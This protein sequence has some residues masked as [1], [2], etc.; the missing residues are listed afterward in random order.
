MAEERINIETKLKITGVEAAGTLDAGQLKF[1]IDDKPLKD[2]VTTASKVA[3]DVKARLDSIQPNKIV[4]DVN[5]N[6]LKSITSQ[7]KNAITA[8]IDQAAAKFSTAFNLN[9]LGGTGQQTRNADGTFGKKQQGASTSAFDNLFKTLNKSFSDLANAANSL[10]ATFAKINKGDQQ[11]EGG[12]FT[13]KFVN[14]FDQF[15]GSV[16]QTISSLNSLDSALKTLSNSLKTAAA[17]PVGAI[18]TT[19]TRTTDGGSTG[20]ISEEAQKAADGASKAAIQ[21]DKLSDMLAGVDLSKIKQIPDIQSQIKNLSK[22]ILSSINNAIAGTGK[23][24][25]AAKA[26]LNKLLNLA[27]KLNDILGKGSVNPLK[28]LSASIKESVK[29]AEKAEQTI[30]KTRAK[31]AQERL[32]EI[33]EEVKADKRAAEEKAKAE[34]ASLRRR[35]AYFEDFTRRKGEAIRRSIEEERQAAQEASRL[36]IERGRGF[37]NAQAALI[38]SDVESDQGAKQEEARKLRERLANRRAFEEL[39]FAQ[40]EKEAAD[41]AARVRQRVSQIRKN[42]TEEEKRVYAQAAGSIETQAQRLERALEQFG[43]RR[44]VFQGAAMAPSAA[45]LTGFMGGGAGGTGGGGGAGGGFGNFRGGAGGDGFKRM[46]DETQRLAKNANDARGPLSDINELSFQVGKK[47]AA[48]RGVAIAINTVVD[49][50]RNATRFVIDLN[51][52]LI[53]LNKILQVSNKSLAIIGDRLFNLAKQT[54]VSV[55]EVVMIAQEFARAGIAG[56]GFGDVVDF[57]SKALTGLQ[58]TTLDA[59]QAQQ[60][61]IQVLQQVEGG[62]RGLDESLIRT[63]KLFDILGK[64]EDITASK[65]QDVQDAFKRSF[66]SLAASGADI[67]QVTA[68]ISVLQERTQRG[69]D[70]IGTAL[71][72]LSARISSSSSEASQALAS[73]GVATTDA[74]GE[75]RSVFDVLRDTAAA[76]RGLTEEE[77]ANIAVKVAGLRQIEILRAATQNFNRVIDVNTELQNANEDATRKQTEE[78][79]KLSVSLNRSSIALQ[80]LVKNLTAGPIGD[81]FSGI[82]RSAEFL[83]TSI[84]ELDKSLGGALTTTLALVGGFAAFRTLSGLVQG[85]TRAITFF[86]RGQEESKTKFAE[87]G[88]AATQ[89]ASTIDRTINAEIRKTSGLIDGV[90]AKL[91]GA[92]TTDIGSSVREGFRRSISFGSTFGNPSRDPGAARALFREQRREGLRRVQGIAPRTTSEIRS[93]AFF[94]R[95]FEPAEKAAGKFA[96]TIGNFASKIGSSVGKLLGNFTTLGIGLSALGGIVTQQAQATNNTNLGLLGRGISGAATGAII[97]GPTGAAVGALGGLGFG[98]LEEALR[99]PQ[100]ESERLAEKYI[101][102]GLIQADLGN[103]SQ[104]ASEKIDLVVNNLRALADFEEKSLTARMEAA[105][106]EDAAI[107]ADR[108]N[109]KINQALD[110]LNTRISLSNTAEENSKNLLKTLSDI[111]AA[112]GLEVDFS[113]TTLFTPGSDFLRNLTSEQFKVIEDSL[114]QISESIDPDSGAELI[115]VLQDALAKT[116]SKA[117]AAAVDESFVKDIEDARTFFLE[118]LTASLKETRVLTP[119]GKV[120]AGQVTIEERLR[121]ALERTTSGETS[122]SIQETFAEALRIARQTG[123]LRAG[124]VDDRG[125]DQ[126]ISA[127]AIE[128]LI[129]Q[130]E[131]LRKQI[132]ER[133]GLLDASASGRALSTAFAP[134]ISQLTQSGVESVKAA[135]EQLRNTIKAGIQQSFSSLRTVTVLEDSARSFTAFQRGFGADVDKLQTGLRLFIRDFSENITTL[136]QTRIDSFVTQRERPQ[137]LLDFSRRRLDVARSGQNI[138]RD[139]ALQEFRQSLTELTGATPESQEQRERFIF[140]LKSAADDIRQNGILDVNQQRQVFEKALLDADI[141]TNIFQGESFDKILEATQKFNKA[142]TEIELDVLQEVINRNKQQVETLNSLIAEEDRLLSIQRRKSE[143]AREQAAIETVGLT[144]LRQL[145]AQRQLEANAIAQTT[146]EQERLLDFIDKQ[147]AEQQKLVEQDPT[148]TGARQNIENLERRREDLLLDIASTVVDAEAKAAQARENLSKEIISQINSEASALRSTVDARRNLINSLTFG[149]GEI[150]SFNRRLREAATSFTLSA[151]EIAAEAQ[152]VLASI[153]DQTEREARLNTLRQQ[154]SDAAYQLAQAEADI[155]NE[156]QQLI[157]QTQQEIVANQEEQVQAQAQV[158]EATKAAGDAYNAYVNAVQDVIAA[159]ADYTLGLSLAGIESRALTNGFSNF[160]QEIAAVQDAFALTANVAQQAGAAERTL[161]EIRRQSV[162]EQINLFNQLL[163]EQASAARSFFTSS[164]QDQ[165]DLF[166]GIREA[167]QVAALLGGSFNKFKSLGEN[168]INE[169]GNQLLSLPQETRQRII[170]SLETLRTVGGSVG[171]FNADEL[172]TAIDTAALGVSS[173]GLDVDP[174]FKVQEKIATLTEEQA[175]L[176][177]EQLISANNQVK[178]SK[179]AVELAEADIDLAE[180]Q[181]ERIQEEGDALRGKLAEQTS[182][183]DTSILKTGQNTVSAIA[184]VESVIRQLDQNIIN[185]LPGQITAGT[186]QLIQGAFANSTLA[187]Q[188][189]S[190]VFGATADINARGQESADMFRQEGSNVAKQ[191]EMASSAGFA[192]SIVSQAFGAAQEQP[193]NLPSEASAQRT[194]EILNQISDRINELNN[195]TSENGIVLAQVQENTDPNTSTATATTT[196]TGASQTQNEFTINVD[197]Q[198][199]VTISGF[200]SAVA[201]L[202]AALEGTFVTPAQAQEIA[203]ALLQSIRDELVRRGILNRNQ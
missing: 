80:G 87:M 181:L 38:R 145:V 106:P 133:E 155:L 22:V 189:I 33:E 82:I 161:V 151:D 94:N 170:S 44:G 118:N 153:Q 179:K 137:A 185:T 60:V 194:N 88:N 5:K 136:Q 37:T 35:A 165:S 91:R 55:D 177:T 59:A 110:S 103:I 50:A 149:E 64:A 27:Q 156:R 49:A 54:G 105:S 41:A 148:N 109:K 196:T 128:G 4:I 84:Q 166:L 184:S 101:K 117:F 93:A 78:Q 42:A 76:F 51:D 131:S 152:V 129:Q 43:T 53:E 173:D 15:A 201:S 85:I 9:N 172:L 192:P 116:S 3:K 144:G 23:Q 112:R 126:R 6:S 139:D 97:G 11:R 19:Q 171:G 61:F 200:E 62:A 34:L 18:T 74:T 58:G 65:A 24:S 193:S 175:R 121:D 12:K 163:S 69:G 134:I 108:A 195:L 198:Q 73:I 124:T 130:A 183:L 45:D 66:A 56:R 86:L 158:I 167:E 70:V 202:T 168:A 98:L 180:I 92:F 67:E 30:R 132:T 75:L 160:K 187:G 154:A 182:S 188:S 114:V 119:F 31:N 57:T 77:Q 120:S 90:S 40:K 28:Q 71:K 169:I 7:V 107:L 164:A 2:L 102:L 48:F 83:L 29:T 203:N 63:T 191:R 138:L 141:G 39:E 174:L 21:I 79:S 122:Q 159:T 46:A 104:A 150:D 1:S 26:E 16:K 190:Q 72:T 52:S 146:K 99:G 115:T 68:I 14:V 13:D 142:V 123:G 143:I 147:I 176:A 125:I 20:R 178:E 111:T 8:G 96:G 199:S 157:Q 197:G 32:R 95:I 17:V 89:T 113:D 36:A 186:Q 81:A 127:T 140:A 25:E 47:A 162:A 135:Q 10:S 100:K